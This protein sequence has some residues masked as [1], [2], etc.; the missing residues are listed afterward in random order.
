MPTAHARPSL[1]EGLF[2][3]DARRMKTTSTSRR[4]PLCLVA[5][6]LGVALVVAIQLMNAAV[7]DSFLDTVDGM[8]GRAAVRRDEMDRV[9]RKLG[10]SKR[11]F[12]EEAIRLRVERLSRDEEHPLYRD[13]TDRGRRSTRRSPSTRLSHRR[14]FARLKHCT[15]CRGGHLKRS[16]QAR[17]TWC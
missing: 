16:P 8:V 10:M 11:Q 4:F 2:H 14:N 3:S 13:A 5:L 1:I 7:L 17:L 15:G 9:T 12:L 6:A